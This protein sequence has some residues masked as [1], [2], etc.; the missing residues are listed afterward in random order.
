MS[1]TSSRKVGRLAFPRV[2]SMCK[3]SVDR[4]KL[5]EG[6]S[7]GV[8]SAKGDRRRA[9]DPTI[10]NWCTLF[11]YITKVQRWACDLNQFNQ[12]DSHK[13]YRTNQKRHRGQWRCEA[14]I[15]AAMLLTMRED[16]VEEESR[17]RERKG[18]WWY[19]PSNIKQ[20]PSSKESF[21]FNSH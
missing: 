11:L 17:E 6:Q 4:R 21:T 3:D 8:K 19:H 9:N 18:S 2:N 10:I 5:K 16:H 20:I 13:F 1:W 12:K 14:Q 7:T 15:V